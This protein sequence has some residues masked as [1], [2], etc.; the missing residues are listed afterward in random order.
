MARQVVRART[1]RAPHGVEPGTKRPALGQVVEQVH[2]AVGAG[3]FDNRR[4]RRGVRARILAAVHQREDRRDPH[5][6]ERLRKSALDQRANGLVVLVRVAEVE[7]EDDALRR[8][9]LAT[10]EWQAAPAR[11]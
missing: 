9:G 2:G 11:R 10:D 8:L 7:V 4:A 5:E 1:E 6:H 3:H